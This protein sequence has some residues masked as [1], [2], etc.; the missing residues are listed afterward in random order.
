MAATCVVYSEKGGVGKT[1]LAYSLARDLGTY[2]FTNDSNID[3]KLIDA[4]PEAIPL[5]SK[6][7][8][9][10][11]TNAVYD[12]SKDTG[13]IISAKMVEIFENSDIVIVPTLF[14]INSVQGTLNTLDTLSQLNLKHVR[15]VVNRYKESEK[16]LE[17]KI[18]EIINQK[19]HEISERAVTEL[20]YNENFTVQTIRESKIVLNASWH[21]RSILE[22]YEKALPVI[23]IA[24]RGVVDDYSELIKKIREV[25]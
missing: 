6:I 4:Y 9:I 2:Y 19:L 11:D 21:A 22:E 8:L 10:E 1:T 12:L 24:Y 23:K 20:V 16:E 25:I 14:D 13:G 18:I 17:K 7:E 5:G 3:Q 15:L